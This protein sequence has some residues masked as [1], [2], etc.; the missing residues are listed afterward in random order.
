M[1]P[2]LTKKSIKD[3]VVPR[4]DTLGLS[5]PALKR[6]NRSRAGTNLSADQQKAELALLI[7][8]R[9]TVSSRDQDLSPQQQ[10]EI[11]ENYGEVEVYVNQPLLDLVESGLL[12]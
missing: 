12:C 3:T 1:A 7:A 6:L 5:E 9:G 4:K 8:E 2:A 10:T 11:E